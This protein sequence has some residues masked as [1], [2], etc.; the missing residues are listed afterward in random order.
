MQDQ[1]FILTIAGLMLDTR[2]GFLAKIVDGAPVEPSQSL[3]PQET[4]IMAF[5]MRFPNI[6]HS[7]NQIIEACF[8]ND[9]SGGPL[10]SVVKEYVSRLRSKMPIGDADRVLQTRYGFGF[11]LFDPTIVTPKEKILRIGKLALDLN[12]KQ[13]SVDGQLINLARAEYNLVERMMRSPKHVFSRQQLMLDRYKSEKVIDV[14]I[15]RIKR[16]MPKGFERAIS[17][18]WGSGYSMREAHLC[19]VTKGEA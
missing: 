10:D 1:N 2:Y 12:L 9:E 14:H 8:A 5:L 11:V 19:D 13:W 18:V 4:D 16:K 3:T 6:V 15:S 17:T 7:K